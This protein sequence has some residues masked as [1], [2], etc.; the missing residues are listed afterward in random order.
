MTTNMA[1]LFVREELEHFEI[2]RLVLENFAVGDGYDEHAIFHVSFVGGLVHLREN[3]AREVVCGDD[4]MF[5]LFFNLT[6]G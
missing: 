6:F 2:E 5:V 1:V 3:E 4:P